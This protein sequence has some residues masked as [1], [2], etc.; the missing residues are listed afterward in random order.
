MFDKTHWALNQEYDP[1]LRTIFWIPTGAIEWQDKKRAKLEHISPALILIHELGHAYHHDRA[2]D[3]GKWIEQTKDKSDKVWSNAEGK[4]T[5][6]EIENVVARE[7]GGVESM[8][9]W[10]NPSV[11]FKHRQYITTS[12]IGIEAAVNVRILNP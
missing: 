11:P 4:R 2:A 5:I 6:E 10:H 7:L 9:S 8:R 1:K 3:P 12:P